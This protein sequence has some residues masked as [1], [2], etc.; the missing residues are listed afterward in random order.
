ME[1]YAPHTIQAAL[2]LVDLASERNL[3]DFKEADVVLMA[4]VAMRYAGDLRH[5][6]FPGAIRLSR[7]VGWSLFQSANRDSDPVSSCLFLLIQA[8]AYQES[9]WLRN[10][11]RG[12][13]VVIEMLRDMPDRSYLLDSIELANLTMDD[14]PRIQLWWSRL[15][16]LSRSL[17][18]PKDLDDYWLI[19][20]QRSFIRERERLLKEGCPY[21]PVLQSIENSTCGYDIL[22]YVF[23][24]T[25]NRWEEL[26]IEVKSSIA[27]KS[28]S[29]YL[30]RN[31]WVAASS[32]PQHWQLDFYGSANSPVI[33]LPYK[34][35]ADLVPIDTEHG[36]WKECQIFKTH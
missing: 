31:E 19:C 15:A 26:W 3:S 25:T 1:E 36:R 4:D 21:F 32:R 7:A 10:A 22:S 18:E 20:E 13:T 5:L 29:F 35:V 6:D 27:T 14:T 23:D 34:T 2:H 9:S 24:K 8:L 17:T 12:R 30:S 28:V 33:I 16:E 11:W